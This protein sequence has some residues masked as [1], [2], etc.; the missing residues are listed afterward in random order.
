MSWRAET[1]G[2]QL[3]WAGRTGIPIH[4]YALMGNH[5]AFAQSYGGE[6]YHLV[7]ETPKANLVREK[8]G[9]PEEFDILGGSP[10]HVMFISSDPC[11]L[12]R[13]DGVSDTTR[14]PEMLPGLS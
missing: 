1:C 14:R 7:I 8:R 6:G 12:R 2:S 9:Q 11:C 10:C 4:A 13:P 3:C 5:P